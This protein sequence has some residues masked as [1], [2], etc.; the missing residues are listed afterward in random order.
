MQ[1][2]MTAVTYTAAVFLYLSLS[3]NC[4]PLI[5]EHE[6][7]EKCPAIADMHKDVIIE[8]VVTQF[9]LMKIP[10]S[11]RPIP[12]PD[13]NAGNSCKEGT[14]RE[15]NDKIN[16]CIS[17]VFEYPFRLV[18]GGSEKEG[19]LEVYMNG[20]WGTVCD[21]DWD[22]IDAR[23]VCQSLGFIGHTIPLLNAT[24]GE[25]TGPIWMSSVNC[26]GHEHSIKKCVYKG[27]H[28][29][30]HNNDAGVRCT[31][32]GVRLVNG[33]S[34]REGRVELYK[35]GEWGTVCDKGWGHQDASVVCRTFGLQ[36]YAVG[37]AAFGRGKGPIVLGNVHCTGKESSLWECQNSK[38]SC[39]HYEDAGVKC[40]TDSPIR[41]VGG[42]SPTEGRVEVYLNGQWGTICQDLF[43]T[44]DAK[45]LCSFLGYG[46][47][48]LG[49][50]S[51]VFGQ[52]TGPVWLN[53]LGCSGEE[54]SVL[55]CRQSQIGKNSC[56]HSR[57]VGIVCMNA[58]NNLVRLVDGKTEG[59]GRVEVL[60]NGQWVGICDS[61]WDWADAKVVCR[62]LGYE[63]YYIPTSKSW[64]GRG[65]SIRL[66]NVGCK[67]NEQSFL[68][69]SNL[70]I[71]ENCYSGET[72]GAI[73]SNETTVRIVNGISESAG[74]VEVFLDG[75]WGN[76]CDNKWDYRDANV[77]CRGLG[78]LGYSMTSSYPFSGNNTREIFATELDCS[79]DEDSIWLCDFSNIGSVNCPNS[80]VAGILCTNE[81]SY[82]LRLVNGSSE[83]EGR[84]EIFINKEWGTICGIGMDR[85]SALIICKKLG[86]SGYAS[87]TK[88]RVFG[89]GLGRIWMSNLTC[90]GS[91]K[92]LSECGKI[93]THRYCS[94]GDDAGVLCHNIT[95]HDTRLVNGNSTHE[96]GVEVFLNGR[97]AGVCDDEWSGMDAKVICKSLGFIGYA[98]VT[99]GSVFRQENSTILVN[100][101][102]CEGSEEFL[103][104]C[105]H[106]VTTDCGISQMAGVVCVENGRN[107]IRLD[108]GSSDNEGRPEIYVNGKWGGICSTKW[109]PTE[110]YI[111]CRSL[112]YLGQKYTSI[113]KNFG[114]GSE[115]FW[116][117]N[118]SCNGRERHILECDHIINDYETCKS[119]S[120]GV[121]CSN[122]VFDFIRLVNGASENEGRLEV[123]YNGEWGT[124]CDDGWGLEDTQVV[125]RSLGYTGSVVYWHDAHFGHGS[126]PIVL[127][128]VRCTGTEASLFNCEAGAVYSCYHWEDVGIRCT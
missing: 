82:E 110:S 28:N 100:Q 75:K 58:T 64:F 41:L 59:A 53:N 24:F 85:D 33:K 44:S 13:I 15:S 86:Y 115:L 72:A 84:V 77:V 29:C 48:G 67:G 62:S 88:S 66:Y 119:G 19:R 31:D 71:G 117:H 68:G 54:L 63:G 97:W 126:G 113:K 93:Y 42:K 4:Q 103:L 25:G 65:T 73:C 80:N 5:E 83:N 52:G 11:D 95:S 38:W 20:Q 81:S 98:A 124:V 45:V 9:S 3:A 120:V 26:S 1:V 22:V 74:T 17:T 96:G 118:V 34:W 10:E 30:S 102:K 123:Y 112:G 111:F 37:S 23:V 36:G 87:V 40:F 35:D 69:C 114:H 79:G 125:C 127:G 55:Q 60:V 56:H 7:L 78:Y 92:S 116:M 104:E 39:G 101:C 6:F 91:E 76:I 107:F 16:E 57:D 105:K 122:A 18:G 32:D 46:F 70:L 99:S 21:E 89:Y 61:T 49:A 2:A 27:K 94:H 12:Q 90:D 8:N 14:G 121:I 43:G 109:S 50:Y 128:N 108:N 47:R 51:S 106:L